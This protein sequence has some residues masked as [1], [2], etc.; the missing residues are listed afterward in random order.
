MSIIFVSLVM[1]ISLLNELKVTI[2]NSPP[3]NFLE[4]CVLFPI[5]MPQR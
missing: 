4:P 3:G 5:L 1:N 2:A